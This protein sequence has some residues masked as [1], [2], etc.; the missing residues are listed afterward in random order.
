MEENKNLYNKEEDYDDNNNEYDSRDDDDD[1]KRRT[2]RRSKNDNDGRTHK[3]P[4]CGKSYLS[5]PALYTH[6]KQKHNANGHSGRGRGRPKKDT[7]EPNPEKLKFNPMD[8]SYFSHDERKGQ[9]ITFEQPIEEV[10]ES[11]YGK[12]HRERNNYKKMNSYEDSESIQFFQKILDNKNTPQKNL[13]PENS[14]CEEIFAEYCCKMANYCNPNY[15]V[16][17]LKFITLFR[18]CVNIQYREKI[19]QEGRDYSEATNAEDVP[20]VSNEFITEFLDPDSNTFGFTKEEAIDLT[21]N[22]CH[23]LYENNFT[24]S[25]LSLIST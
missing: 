22:F 1:E 6:I 24:C 19:R 3:C 11:I 9:T 5:Y 10:F 25:K 13:D 17:L 20:D 12:S 2:K 14:K 23:W 7:G 4:S 8:M 18:E 21:Q 16:K 15:F